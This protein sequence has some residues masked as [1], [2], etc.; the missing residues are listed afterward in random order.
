[1]PRPNHDVP[2][3]ALGGVNDYADEQD[4]S[5]DEA[6]TELLRIALIEVGILPGCDDE[7]D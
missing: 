3:W 4:I 2:G 7:D 5:R 6:H 1:M